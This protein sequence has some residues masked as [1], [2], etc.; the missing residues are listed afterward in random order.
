MTAE[1]PTPDKWRFATREM[2]TLVARRTVVPFGQLLNPYD[3]RCGWIHLTHLA[4][5]E[6]Y[7]TSTQAS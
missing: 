1:C 3:C 2:A 7:Q 5:A 6:N 4:P